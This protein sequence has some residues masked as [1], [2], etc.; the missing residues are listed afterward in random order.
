MARCRL[1]IL[2][3]FAN[4]Y[5]HNTPRNRWRSS[6]HL[7]RL[8]QSILLWNTTNTPITQLYLVYTLSCTSNS[9]PNVTENCGYT[10]HVAPR[11]HRSTSVNLHCPMIPY[12][13]HK[14]TFQTK[15]WVCLSVRWFNFYRLGWV[16]L[17]N[18]ANFRNTIAKLSYLCNIG[19]M[20][21]F[22]TNVTRTKWCNDAKVAWQNHLMPR[23]SILV[24][25]LGAWFLVA[26]W[27]VES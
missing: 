5:W 24:P 12:F 7:S 1:C 19:R 27:S 23:L 2:G 6:R 20:G 8:W 25:L 4:T 22:W 14:C 18:I 13:D 26:I 9:T 15:S 21:I 17:S 16:G 10:F 3:N 11:A